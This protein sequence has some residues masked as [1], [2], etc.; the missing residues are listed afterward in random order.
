MLNPLLDP[1]A[2]L[3]ISFSVFNLQD[4][5]RIGLLRPLSPDEVNTAYVDG[6]NDPLVTRWLAFVAESVAV[7]SDVKQYVR[8]N[9]LDSNAV[10]FGLFVDSKLRG[11]V[12]IHAIDDSAGTAHIGIAIFDKSLWGLAWGRSVL[13]AV[14]KIGLD[15][16]G[17]NVLL[18]GIDEKNIASIKVFEAA[19]FAVV[20]GGSKPYG[21]GNAL[22]FSV[23]R[24]T[25]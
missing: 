14:T 8:A 10:L 2:S 1:D 3:G 17:L 15:G 13:R 23:S 21:G 18:A 25:E 11:T 16:L 4:P 22:M 12:R 6:L 9:L 24:D 7:E 20:E 5:D 19:G